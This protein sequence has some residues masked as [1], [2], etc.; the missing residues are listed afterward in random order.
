MSPRLIALSGPLS[1][2]VFPLSDG[3]F[4]L[5]RAESNSVMIPDRAVSR[6]HCLI[7]REAEHFTLVDLQSRN[8]CS[9]NNVPVREHELHHGDRV[10]IGDSQFV[11]LVLADTRETMSSGTVELDDS[12][13]RSARTIQL[14]PEDAVYLQPQ[15]WLAA[16][17]PSER[18]ARDLEALLRVCQAL[19][20]RHDIATL[21]AGLLKLILDLVPADCGAVLLAQET[22]EIE[23]V[24]GCWRSSDPD[25]KVPVSRTLVRQVLAGKAALLCNDVL[26]DARISQTESV[27]ASPITALL[28]VPIPGREK[29]VGVLYLA[30]SNL[31]RNF[32]EAD[33]QLVTGLAVVSAPAFESARQ[34]ER[35]QEENRRLHEEIEVEHRMIGD[36]PAMEEVYRFIGKAAPANATVL[37]TGESGTGKELVARALHM[38]SARSSGPF[39]PVNCA[40]LTE[41]LLE[42]ELFGHEK[43]AFTGAVAAKKGLLEVASGGTLFL[44]E[45]AEMKPNLQAKLLRVLQERQFERVG[46]IETLKVDIRVIAATNRDLQKAIADESFRRDLYYRIEVLSVHVPP[47]R[48]RREDIIPLARFFLNRHSRREKRRDLQLSAESEA[49]LNQYDWP[50]NVREL[51]SAIEQAVVLTSGNVIQPA[52]LSENVRD[53]ADGSGSR[54]QFHEAVREAKKQAILRAFKQSGGSYTETAQLLG[55]HA[56]YLHRVI[57]SLDL[58]AWLR[59]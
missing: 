38:N 5:G 47:L 10:T 40:A 34:V 50:G 13:I 14:K 52:D 57:R 17:A 45:I 4:T 9:V 1:G 29:P 31:V 18:E 51:E 56:N 11:F 41:T 15:R 6:R 44:D 55:L 23:A 42:S 19:D 16:G 54:G 7:R 48:E 12:H 37:I 39:V 33:L 3:D 25:R 24:Q 21:A 53:A 26:Q 30:T 35:L 46:G 43:G 22:G 36:S 2:G 59:P 49:C 32:D 27:A 28:V 8:G 58:K 20:F